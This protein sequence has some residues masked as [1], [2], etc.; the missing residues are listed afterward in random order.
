MFGGVFYSEGGQALEHVALRSCGCP[1][2]GG[3]Q[4]QVGR[5]PG[6]S[7]PVGGSPDRGR[8]LEL[9][10]LQSSFHP[11]P[12]YDSMILR[13]HFCICLSQQEIFPTDLPYQSLMSPPRGLQLFLKA[14][15]KQSFIIIIILPRKIGSSTTAYHSSGVFHPGNRGV[16]V[17]HFSPRRGSNA[18]LPQDRRAPAT[19]WVSTSFSALNVM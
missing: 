2:P 13:I 7:D 1:I 3:I 15:T 18:Y 16:V 6:Q 12:F 19:R 14:K 9:D 10:D 5:G 8:G 11:K 4:G 17:L